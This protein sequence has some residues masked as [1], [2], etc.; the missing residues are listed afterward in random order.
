M[1][2]IWFGELQYFFSQRWPRFMKQY[3]HGDELCLTVN[4]YNLKGTYLAGFYQMVLFAWKRSIYRTICM[5]NTCIYFKLAFLKSLPLFGP[6]QLW[7]LKRFWRLDFWKSSGQ[8]H[9][10]FLLFL[11]FHPKPIL[12]NLPAAAL[13]VTSVQIYTLYHGWH[14][15]CVSVYPKPLFQLPLA[16]NLWL[17]FFFPSS[18][19]GC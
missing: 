2:I 1:A 18:I 3:W 9:H 11:G 15:V 19:A 6:A 7:L 5:C 8:K 4:Y 14:V 17:L 13:E 10:I 12:F 16:D